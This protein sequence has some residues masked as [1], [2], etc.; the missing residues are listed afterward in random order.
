M[1]SS[2]RM[3]KAYDT[4]SALRSPRDQDADVFRHFSA[5]LRSASDDLSRTRALAGTITLWRTVMAA[6]LDPLNP[7]PAP[8]RAQIV[9]VAN[10]VIRMAEQDQP[11]LTTI[12]TI[13]DN[14]ADG[15]SGR[16]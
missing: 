14:F 11:N 9:S 7:L 12:A 13:G 10:A 3:V 4:A 1:S 2:T 16:T 5:L 15:L 6:N 8:L